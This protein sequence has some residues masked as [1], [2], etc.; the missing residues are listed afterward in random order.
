M[1]RN[2]TEL[3][4]CG[5]IYFMYVVLSELVSYGRLDQICVV[6]SWASQSQVPRKLSK[7]AFPS[8]PKIQVKWCSLLPTAALSSC[9]VVLAGVGEVSE[10]GW[11]RGLLHGLER[12][13]KSSGWGFMLR[14]RGWELGVLS[15]I[16]DTHWVFCC[17]SVYVLVGSWLLVRAEQLM[18]HP[19]H[20]ALTGFSCASPRPLWAGSVPAAGLAVCTSWLCQDFCSLQSS[21]FCV[22]LQWLETSSNTMETQ[23]LFC[24]MH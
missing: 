15:V 10:L 13:W 14:R 19:I 20:R 5:Y 12:R 24:Q 18:G 22:L 16:C 1:Y 9:F 6:L 21:A 11:G 3:C 4:V 2:N 8:F 7:P 23:T 17:W